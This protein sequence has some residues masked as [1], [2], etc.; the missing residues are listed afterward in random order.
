MPGLTPSRCEGL[1]P[2]GSRSV[3]AHVVRGLAGFAFLA[4]A[5]GY[6]SRLGWWTILPAV[7]ALVMFRGCPMCWTAGLVETVLRRW[8]RTPGAES[9]SCVDGSCA[10]GTK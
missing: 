6:A 7:G 5:L 1:T 9:N 8:K 4:V 10:G 2:F 3:A